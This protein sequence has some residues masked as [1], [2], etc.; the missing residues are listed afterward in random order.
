[1]AVKMAVDMAADTAADMAVDMAVQRGEGRRWR[2]TRSKGLHVDCSHPV[3]SGIPAAS[4][5]PPPQ[6]FH[7]HFH[8][9]F[10]RHFHRHFHEVAVGLFGAL[11][12]SFDCAQQPAYC[13]T[14]S[15]N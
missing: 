7:R 9:H 13:L 10:R 5:P 12:C 15:V 11:W 14:Q 4:T 1:M 3:A 2:V 8:R 6:P